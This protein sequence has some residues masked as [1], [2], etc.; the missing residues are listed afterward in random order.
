MPEEFVYIDDMSIPHHCSHPKAVTTG[1]R[2]TRIVG[3][4]QKVCHKHGG[5]A[6]QT[7]RKTLDRRNE[8]EARARLA[9]KAKEKGIDRIEDAVEELEILM[10][11][12]KAFKDICRDRLNAIGD[13]WRYKASAGEQLRAEVALY[14]RAIDRCNKILT[15]YVRLGI[16][17]K[18]VRI[19]EAQ[20]MILVGVIQ[21][22]LGQLGLTREQKAIAATVVPAELRAI[23]AA[24]EKD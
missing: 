22:I 2:C 17:E 8:Y 12:A 11:E 20:A 7:K 6:P 4:G 18:R 15:D 23:S 16:A 1:K 24:P 13:E 10:S 3:V 19:Q 9:K 5:N 14:E 21:S